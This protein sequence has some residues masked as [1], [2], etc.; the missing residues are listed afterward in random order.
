MVRRRNLHRFVFMAAGVYNIAWGLYATYDPQWFFRFAG[1]LPLNHPQ[2][3]QCLGM[4]IG[5]YGL[6]YFEVAR[7]PE[8]GWFLAALGLSG[9]ILGPIGLA[10]S[11]WK[12]AW[13]K[14][15]IVLCVTND[16]IWW[17]PFSLYLFDSWPAFRVDREAHAQGCPRP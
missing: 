6:A 17:V 5:L 14:S 16:L 1:L 7:A 4:V 9:K 3:F 15:T 13:P 8:R 2:I 11:I 12:Y 10:V